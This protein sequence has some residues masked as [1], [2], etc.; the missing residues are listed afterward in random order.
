MR[1]VSAGFETELSEFSGE[2]SHDRLL[3]NFPP[4]V[5]LSKRVNSPK[6]AIS[7]RMR[8]EFPTCSAATGGRTGRSPARTSPDR[9]AGARVSVLRQSTEQQNQPG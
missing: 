2:P 4:K 5:A 3:V 7:R 1:D 8:R 6:G 9:P